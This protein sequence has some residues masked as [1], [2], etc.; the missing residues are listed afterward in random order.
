MI[1]LAAV[2]PWAARTGLASDAIH[3][4]FCD[5]ILLISRHDKAALPAG[6][7]QGIH[8]MTPRAIWAAILGALAAGA[9]AL[10]AA[11]DPAA[12]I[13]HLSSTPATRLDLSLARLSQTIDAHGAGDGYSGFA[14][15]E[16]SDIVIRVYSP[17]AKPDQGSC[18]RILD[19]VKKVGGV[20]P[21]TGEP[22]NP[23]SAYAAL[24]TY[25]DDDPSKIDSSYDETVDSMFRVMVV[26]G[27]TGNGKGM[28][29]ES[30]LLSNKT[31]YKKQ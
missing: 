25:P 22:D 26:I 31:T 29:C 8:A 5:M 23:A 13:S 17:T 21:K 3:Y 15:I 18:R 30:R 12:I 27:Q 20:D 16:N 19:W 6:K 11:A 9:I 2:G 10:P 14:D 24:F 7:L 28:T 1:T 4:R